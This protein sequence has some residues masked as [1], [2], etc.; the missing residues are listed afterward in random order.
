MKN[1]CLAVILCMTIA[2]CT[3]CE[4]TGLYEHVD[5]W[6]N[7]ANPDVV[8]MAIGVNDF[9]DNG[10]KHPVNYSTTAPQR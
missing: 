9:Y 2:I 7:N 10:T 4:T 1:L 5:T 6:L 8:L 3:G